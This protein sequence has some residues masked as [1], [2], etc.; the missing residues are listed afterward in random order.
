MV[1]GDGD[2]LF[3]IKDLAAKL[4]LMRY[5]LFTGFIFDRGELNRYLSTADIFVDAAP[6]SFLNDSSTFIKHMEY[7][8]FQK[9]VISFALKESMFSL[10]DAGVFIQPNDTE[11]MARAI[12]E[13]VRDENRRKKYGIKAAERVKELSWDRVSQP[14]LQAYK[15]LE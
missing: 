2:Y 8:V 13:L 11:E 1:I 7:M 6:Y 5:V 12:L 4:D 15:S 10:G 9:P 3:R 14:L